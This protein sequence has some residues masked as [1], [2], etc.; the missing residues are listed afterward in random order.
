M[1][2]TSPHTNNTQVP[3]VPIPADYSEDFL[4]KIETIDEPDKGNYVFTAVSSN[5]SSSFSSADT[6]CTCTS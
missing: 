4:V 6:C 5:H 2:E 3:G 1:P